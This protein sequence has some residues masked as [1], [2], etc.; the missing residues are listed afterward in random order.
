VGRSHLGEEVADAAVVGKAPHR[1]TRAASSA[2]NIGRGGAAGRKLTFYT[3]LGIGIY[4]D[5][6]LPQCSNH[7]CAR[8]EGGTFGLISHGLL[9][10]WFIGPMAHGRVDRA[11]GGQ[12][13][14]QARE[15]ESPSAPWVSPQSRS[16]AL[17]RCAALLALLVIGLIVLGLLP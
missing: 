17:D 11:A 9:V 13:R 10:A 16:P 12:E 14:M 6:R 4:V 15:Y 8:R 7:P 3:F 2:E 1:A 5:R